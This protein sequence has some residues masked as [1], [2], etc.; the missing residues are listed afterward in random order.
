MASF[1]TPQSAVANKTTYVRYKFMHFHLL[2]AC[3]S[4]FIIRKSLEK[5]SNK[6]YFF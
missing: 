2:Y 3:K 6:T 5:L 1:T 4:I